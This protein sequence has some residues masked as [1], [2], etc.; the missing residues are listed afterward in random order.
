MASRIPLGASGKQSFEVSLKPYGEE[1]D[2]FSG[3]MFVTGQGR[4]K[5]GFGTLGVINR[6]AR[7]PKKKKDSEVQKQPDS[8]F[9]ETKQ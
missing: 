7:P 4:S 9:T 6:P 8:G 1:R 5:G 3:F 2:E